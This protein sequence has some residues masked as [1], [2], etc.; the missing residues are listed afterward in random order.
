MDFFLGL[1]EETGVVPPP[2]ASRPDLEDH[3]APVW[4]AFWDLQGERRISP[5][6]MVRPLPWTAVE[7]WAERFG[8]ADPD[9]FDWLWSRL[10][11]LDRDYLDFE[12]ARLDRLTKK[13]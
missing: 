3:L 1:A 9:G 8:W 6:G 13:V 12:A 2:L 10:Q 4:T 7:R 11:G 5:S